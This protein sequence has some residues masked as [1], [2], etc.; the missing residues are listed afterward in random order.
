V[1]DPNEAIFSAREKNDAERKAAKCV[2]FSTEV[3]VKYDY[4]LR[5]VLDAVKSWQPPKDECPTSRRDHGSVLFHDDIVRWELNEESDY[6]KLDCLAD[7]DDPDNFR[8]WINLHIS[9]DMERYP[10]RA[11]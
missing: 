6:L 10:R 4:C 7:L 1:K 9:L 2:E 8:T 5:E 3:R 11:H